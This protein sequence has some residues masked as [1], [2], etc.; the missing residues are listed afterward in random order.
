MSTDEYV[1]NED[2]VRE[3][4][5]AHE[6]KCAWGPYHGNPTADFDAFLA[7][8]RR[9]AARSG[10]HHGYNDRRLERDYNHAY[11]ETEGQT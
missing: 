5:V 11:P 10:Y 9:D 7:R 4:W 1:P 6:S 8:V 3:T 2:D